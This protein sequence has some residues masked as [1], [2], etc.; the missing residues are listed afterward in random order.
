M[1]LNFVKIEEIKWLPADI[2]NISSSKSHYAL[3]LFVIDRLTD[4]GVIDK[5][6]SSIKETVKILQKVAEEN[7]EEKDYLFEEIHELTGIS[8][9]EETSDFFFL[10]EWE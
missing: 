9:N 10:A 3:L 5:F 2:E 8:M 4:K 6:K 1:D 7:F